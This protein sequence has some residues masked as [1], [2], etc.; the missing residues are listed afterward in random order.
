MDS[1]VKTVKCSEVQDTCIYR[2]KSG[3]D[4]IC[5]YIGVTG[6]SRRCSPERCDKYK[7]KEG[8]ARWIKPNS[9]TIV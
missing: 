5:D 2:G 9:K 3:V 1:Q 8:D 7:K 6:R 4:V